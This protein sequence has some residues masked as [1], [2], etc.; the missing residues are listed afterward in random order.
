MKIRN[1]RITIDEDI[2]LSDVVRT[3]KNEP[4]VILRNPNRLVDELT[5]DKYEKFFKYQNDVYWGLGIENE[6]YIEFEKKIS[7]P[8]D[9]IQNNITRE[10]Y[11]I[12]YAMNYKDDDLKRLLKYFNQ[13]E[14]YEITQMLNSHCF[15]KLDSKLNHKTIY[16]L[17]PTP[18]ILFN[19]KS[20]YE[21]WI[22][23][24]PDIAKIF[25]PTD[26][27][28]FNIFFDG[29]AIEFT[30]EKFFNANIKNIVLELNQRKNYFIN[31]L[32][33]FFD[34]NNL[35]TERGLV[36]FPI[37]NPGFNHFLSQKNGIVLFN[38]STYHINI[39][40]PTKLIDGKIFNKQK[41]INDHRKAISLIQWFEPFFICTL[42]S[43]DI[44]T[45][46]SDVTGDNAYYAKGSMRAAMSRYIGIGTYNTLNMQ[47]GRILTKTVDEVRPIGVTWWRDLIEKR[48]NYNLPDSQI[49][50]DFNFNKHYQSGFE[51]RM[52]DGF[53]IEYLADVI[54]SII[55]ICA[56]ALTLK[57]VPIAANND[58]WNIIVYKSLVN[59]FDTIL[60]DDEKKE[61]LKS[62]EFKD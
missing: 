53:P 21:E 20:I 23:F 22:E 60:T 6:T 8:G 18:N 10:R 49:G 28:N 25:S 29:D 41:F 32:R 27:N 14:M 38:N 37:V 3:E 31:K 50:L 42:G 11:S 54:R 15:D 34:K 43:P 39:T 5:N 46:L 55:L 26:K 30:T 1:N 12:N 13:F 47:C 4:V 24:D 57:N 19:G 16:A 45:V 61:L 36:S 7:V 44:F 9:F 62:Y 59:G 48:L 35:F 40:L 51:F 33:E 56:H 58:I 2:E 52:L 17:K